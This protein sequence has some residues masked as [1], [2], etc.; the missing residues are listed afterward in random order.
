MPQSAEARVATAAR[1]L[2]CVELASQG[3][4]YA[5]IASAV[6]YANKSSARK[7][8]VAALAA[9]EVDGVDM[10]RSLEVTR[11]DELQLASWDSAMT[12]DPQAVDRIVRIINLRAKLL[13]LFEIDA[14][15]RPPRATSVVT[16]EYSVESAGLGQRRPA[17][18]PS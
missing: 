11:L 16:G 17:A 6:G 18:R 13:G 15:G 12:G 14:D 2:R 7:A 10:L 5:E 3:L 8:V 4:T 9:R 1:R